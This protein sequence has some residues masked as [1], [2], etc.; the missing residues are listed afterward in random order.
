MVALNVIQSSAFGTFAFQRR[1][2]NPNAQSTP[3]GP[4]FTHPT[5]P[6]HAHYIGGTTPRSTPS[7]YLAAIQSLLESY[8]LDVQLTSDPLE[9][10]DDD[11]RISDVIPLVVNTMG[12]NKGLGADLTHKIEDL[13][14]PTA[15]YE[16][17]A[18]ASF[19][20]EWATAAPP[21]PYLSQTHPA[22]LH[23]LQPIP[24]SVL[25]TNYSPADH[26]ALSILSYFYAV[27]PDTTSTTSGDLSLSELTAMS[28]NTSL[29]LCARPPYEVEPA[30][31]FE[32]IVLTGAGMEDVVPEEIGR[33]LNG[34]IVGLVSCQP[35][36]LDNDIS[37]S[38]S[39][40]SQ[41]MPYTQGSFP[42]SPS[43]SMCHGLALIRSVSSVSPS[44]G[45]PSSQTAIQMHIIT[46]L[47][48]S[49]LSR[50]TVLIKGELELPIWGMLDLSDGS[51]SVGGVE[52]TKVPYLQWGKG[53]GIGGE[54]R[55]IRRNLMRRGQM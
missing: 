29:S 28:W 47:P 54:R 35:G 55:R 7:H 40:S 20:Q 6:N 4:P 9:S 14:Q 8:R 18:P 5:L 34:A 51:G 50:S 46:T 27:F 31:T 41:T 19:E 53:E 43:T 30:R 26:R 21:P 22:N 37:M 38:D 33:V 36:T 24:P 44:S 12:W 2:L 13:V 10:D 3:S 16:I 15:I 17:E 39:P 25:S 49:L 45:P 32:R 42:P 52:K 1:F 23:T 11:T 48:P